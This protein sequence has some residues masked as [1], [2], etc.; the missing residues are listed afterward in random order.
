MAR[1]GRKQ[2]S[3]ISRIVGILFLQAIAIIV[4][5][6]LAGVA[7]QERATRNGPTVEETRTE[8]PTQVSIE[9]AIRKPYPYP[10]P[11]DLRVEK[12][13]PKVAAGRY[14]GGW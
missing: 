11:S 1:T 13:L 3:E 6:T 9:P 2:K 14:N 4:L 7:Q 5:L 8:I 10:E 12:S